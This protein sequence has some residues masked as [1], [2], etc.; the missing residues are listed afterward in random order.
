MIESASATLEVAGGVVLS[1]RL[2]H[3]PPC[4]AMLR[5]APCSISHDPA[6]D[7]PGRK[8]HLFELYPN[9]A[10]YVAAGALRVPARRSRGRWVGSTR[11]RLGKLCRSGVPEGS[12]VETSTAEHSAVGPAVGLRLRT[13]IR[14]HT[15]LCSRAPLSLLL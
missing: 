6:S 2:R 4:S 3:A 7:R 15:D 5:H 9:R 14:P 13:Q 8:V 11:G 10:P 12:S 1:H